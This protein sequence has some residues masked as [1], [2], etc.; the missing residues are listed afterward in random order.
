MISVVNIDN[1]NIPFTRIYNRLGYRKHFTEIDKNDRL[2]IDSVI[3]E[4]VLLSELRA[5]YSIENITSSDNEI[6]LDSGYSFHSSGLSGM[7]ENCTKAGIFVCTAGVRI[8]LERDNLMRTGEVTKSVIYDAVGSEMA[9]EA[10]EYMHEFL[11]KML[12][13]KGFSTTFRRYSPGYGDLILDDQIKIFELLTP[14]RI[15][16]EISPSFIMKPEKSVSAFI[17]FF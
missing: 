14:G 3:K 17:G 15:G 2:K 8:E 4:A 7:M 11:K 5:V 9:E 13:V 6:I 10:A 12:S 16:V 1:V